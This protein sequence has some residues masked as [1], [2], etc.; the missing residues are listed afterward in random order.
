MQHTSF[1]ARQVR[2]NMVHR[3]SMLLM[4]Y[5]DAMGGSEHCDPKVL[6]LH[7]TA[8]NWLLEIG[9]DDV[10]EAAKLVAHLGAVVARKV[11]SAKAA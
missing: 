4:K 7:F 2:D 11:R 10:D 8:M 6:D 3:A 1:R 5:V 9:P